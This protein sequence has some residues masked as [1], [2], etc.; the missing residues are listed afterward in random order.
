MNQL[1]ACF[2]LVTFVASLAYV[3][4]KPCDL[5]TK[6]E[7]REVKHETLENEKWKCE[8]M[9]IDAKTKGQVFFCTNKI[10]GSHIQVTYLDDGKKQ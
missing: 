2:C 6:T 7:T 10:N 9:G 5:V 3:K 1:R 4:T 8:P